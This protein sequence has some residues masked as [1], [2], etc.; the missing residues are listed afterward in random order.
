MSL[1]S[2]QPKTIIKIYLYAS[3]IVMLGN[4]CAYLF[5][6]LAARGL[7]VED[8][9]ATSA[10]LNLSFFMIAPFSGASMAIS[11]A[12]IDHATSQALM[13]GLVRRIVVMA[14]LMAL[15]LFV[16]FWCMSS[17]LADRMHLD[18][19]TAGVLFPA[20]VA[21]TSLCLVPIGIWQAER[22]HLAMSV[23]T[24]SVP[25]LRLLAF[26]ILVTWLGWG[27]L[28]AMLALVL[29][30]VMMVL[31]SLVSQ[32][33]YWQGQSE[34]PASTAYRDM[35]SF[36]GPASLGSFCLLALTY[37]D[38]P[39]VRS[40]G[41]P[42]QSGLYAAA[43]TL[44]KIAL[45]LPSAL[46]NIVFPEAVALS[47]TQKRQGESRRMIL[48]ALLFTMATSGGV[49]LVM[50]LAP[51]LC[52]EMLGG[53]VYQ[54]AGGILRGLAPAMSCM[55]VV[56]L[57]VTYAMACNRMILLA[58]CLLAILVI[59]AVALWQALDPYHIAY[60]VFV[61]LAGLAVACIIWLVLFLNTSGRD[62]R[63]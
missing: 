43:S 16:V 46:V 45:L 30:C 20:L 40:L 4:A 7:S 63:T 18:N 57:I 8:F 37:M 50:V 33:H 44:A 22:A 12:L 34:A 42:E 51:E 15:V 32:S 59:P 62:S 28:G 47:A 25:V 6:L 10:L 54:N 23:G 26:S 14:A 41:S 36:A 61:C 29:S 19:L 5:Q 39:L 48:L 38:V 17:L 11:K 55:A 49:A 9:G 2:S 52:F 27:L 31:G 60:L 35:L 24:A 1:Q 58:P 3:A 56:S 21:S 13:K 53:G